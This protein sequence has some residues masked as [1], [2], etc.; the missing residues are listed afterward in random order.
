MQSGRGIVPKVSWQPDFQSMVE[1][2]VKK[3]LALFLWEE[4]RGES[5]RT[6]L[7]RS[8]NPPTSIALI[9]GPEG[10]FSGEEAKQ[11]ELAG[12]LPVTLGRRIL[13][14]ETAP[15]CA[16]SAVMFATGNLE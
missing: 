7:H 15:I 1:D 3:E 11:A 8:D 12:L 9:T 2:A 16:L 6:A 5:L 14:C 10:G 13:R 4:A